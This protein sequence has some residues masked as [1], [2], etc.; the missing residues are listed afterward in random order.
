MVL[1]S[2]PT[3]IYFSITRYT[4]HSHTLSPTLITTL[5]LTSQGYDLRVF[6]CVWFA[7]Y[8]YMICILESIS[9]WLG[10][11][12]RTDG[13]VMPARTSGKG[14]GTATKHAKRVKLEHRC[15]YKGNGW[16]IFGAWTHVNA[17]TEHL[18]Q[19]MRWTEHEH[20][21]TEHCYKACVVE[22]FSWLNVVRE[23][24][25]DRYLPLYVRFFCHIFLVLLNDRLLV[26]SSREPYVPHW[27]SLFLA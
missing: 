1:F 23:S 8:V 25:L 16:N 11:D 12:G 27:L 14:R 17:T 15:T 26:A 20:A 4:P 2:A 19:S 22:Y 9:K 3:H 18:L 7:Y 13:P 10:S 5:H 24:P 6:L 21:T